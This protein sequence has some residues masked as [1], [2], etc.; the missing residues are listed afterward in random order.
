MTLGPIPR[1]VLHRFSPLT[2]KG[3][4]AKL[5]WASFFPKAT[6]QPHGQPLLYIDI[7]HWPTLQLKYIPIHTC[8][9]IIN[10]YYCFYKD[11]TFFGKAQSASHPLHFRLGYCRTS[12]NMEWPNYWVKAGLARGSVT[13]CIYVATDISAHDA[14]EKGQGVKIWW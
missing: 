3:D 9:Y 2:S 11:K 12:Q 7:D 13:S 4:G 8:N 6:L 10:L 1:E 5:D 14:S